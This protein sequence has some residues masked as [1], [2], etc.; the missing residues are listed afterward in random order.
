[1]PMLP[2]LLLALLQRRGA[3]S[4][5]SCCAAFADALKLEP[6]RWLCVLQAVPHQAGQSTSLMGPVHDRLRHQP[7]LVLWPQC[8]F[9]R[10]I[11]S[12]MMAT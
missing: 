6:L 12:F 9:H 10:F 11:H 4:V 2:P 3:G 7:E 1:V 8:K 5:H